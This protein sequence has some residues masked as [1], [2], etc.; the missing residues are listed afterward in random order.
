LPICHQDV[1]GYERSFDS[2]DVVV[3]TSGVVH[4]IGTDSLI[5]SGSHLSFFRLEPKSLSFGFSLRGDWAR[6]VVNSRAMTMMSIILEHK[7]GRI[8]ADS[9]CAKLFTTLGWGVRKV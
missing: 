9:L 1:S 6:E 5:L 3:G 7:Y 4:L 2:N 8:A